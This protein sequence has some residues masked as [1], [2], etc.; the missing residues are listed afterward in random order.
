MLDRWFR[1]IGEVVV[2]AA[3]LEVAVGTLAYALDHGGDMSRSYP[4]ML[5]DLTKH[6]RKHVAAQTDTG[7]ATRL[8]AA[9]DEVSALAVRRNDLVHGWWRFGVDG[10]DALRGRA[11][12]RDPDLTVSKIPLTE[13]HDLLEGLN[14]CRDRVLHLA[15]DLDTAGS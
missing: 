2:T 11:S 3:Y 4:L 5:D 12:R 13:L 10:R 7:V 8:E 9:L 15:M 6:C 1:I 14:T